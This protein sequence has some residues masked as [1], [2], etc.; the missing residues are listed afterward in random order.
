[1]IITISGP[2]GSGKDTVARIL[3]E[4]LNYG[5]ISLGNIK[6]EAAQEKGMTIE[7]YNAWGDDN[8]EEA[9][10]FF[11]NQLVEYGKNHENF[12]IIAR[13]GWFFIP[14][15]KKIFVNVDPFEGARRI[16]EQKLGSG[17]GD[18]EYTVNSIDEQITLNSERV[19]GERKR[20]KKLYGADP[21]KT[22][23]YDVV[24]DSTK[25]SPEGVVD[26][27]MEALGL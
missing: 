24:V 13:L 27:I 14:H 16:Y 23:N 25:I 21:Y 12:I 15:S 18:S 6:R 3:A 8:P 1:M 7:Q 4:K 10:R 22:E 2:P 11:D 5:L 26:K 19:E 9:D 20:Y 17:R